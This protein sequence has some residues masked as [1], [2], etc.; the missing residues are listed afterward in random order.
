[1][2]KTKLLLSGFY[3]FRTQKRLFWRKSKELIDAFYNKV[4]PSFKDESKK[5]FKDAIGDLPK[6][7]PNNE[8]V[9]VDGHYSM[10]GICNSGLMN[11]SARY[12]NSRDIKIFELLARDIESGKNEYLPI[13]S[14][15][16]LYTKLT[17]HTSN[18]HKYNV[19][20]WDEPSTTIPAHLCK[21]GLRH[22]HP[23]SKQ[24]RTLTVR[25]AARI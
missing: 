5:T 15:K 6:L 12:H 22:I 3:N 10:H 20:K 16:E 24:A 19:L 23:D 25:E 11:H 2:G 14:R 18:I 8:K 9:K 21:D 4:L 1:M 17:G 13:E 7:Y